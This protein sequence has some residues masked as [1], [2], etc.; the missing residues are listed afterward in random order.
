MKNKIARAIAFY[1]PQFYPTPEN[2]TWWGKGFTEWSNVVKAKPLYWGHEQP[3][4]PA[5][6]GYYDLRSS[7]T[8][9]AQSELARRAGIEGFCYWH[10]WFGNGKRLL[11]RPFNEVLASGKPDFPFCLGW[12]NHSWERKSWKPGNNNK[13]L[14]AQMYP[15]KEDYTAHFY[16]ML[17]AFKD[18][19]YIRVDGK[20]I[21]LIW[22]PGS[23]PDS[24]E[25]INLW[26]K[27]S[28]ENGLE[29]FYFIAYATNKKSANQFIKKG[30]NSAAL[31]LMDECSQNRTIY[32]KT[33]YRILKALFSV[34]RIIDYENYTKYFI[35]N[36]EETENMLPIILPNYDHSPRSGKFGIVLNNSTPEKFGNFLHH[37]LEKL[38]T[39]LF[40]QNIV[41]IKSWNEWGEGNYLEPDIKY[42]KQYLDIFKKHILI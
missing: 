6:L 18:K 15:G 20:P 37:L 30:Y 23:L 22:S 7:E 8:R 26:N 14:I 3:K 41:F 1:L 42:G 39:R 28:I 25:F 10:Y 4:I 29:G 17:D 35:D 32:R 34:P 31:D 9:I 33:A 36:F 27:L 12:A 13:L 5:E 21:F 40:E 2:D 19:R 11:E 38:Q 24:S 16:A